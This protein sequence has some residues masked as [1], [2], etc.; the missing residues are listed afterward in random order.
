MGI[1][2]ENQVPFILAYICMLLIVVPIVT[3]VLLSL[4]QKGQKSSNIKFSKNEKECEGRGFHRLP[5]NGHKKSI[6]GICIDCGL[7]FLKTRCG[8]G[9]HTEK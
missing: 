1:A 3:F 7:I 5:K 9:M 6:W 4:S 8:I 2:H